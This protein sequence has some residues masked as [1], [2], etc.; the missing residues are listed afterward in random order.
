MGSSKKEETC[1]FAFI[2]AKEREW[3]SNMEHGHE[4][5]FAN[6]ATKTSLVNS[7][8][9]LW[10]RWILQVHL[11][12]TKYI[13]STISMKVW[14]AFFSSNYCCTF[15][16]YCTYI[17][18]PFDFDDFF[19]SGHGQWCGCRCCCQYVEKKTRWRCV[20]PGW[21]FFCI[22]HSSIRT[23]LCSRM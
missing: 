7:L 12:W 10:I 23:M 6:V 18:H 15:C 9:I 3:W 20:Q 16:T 1:T 14:A 4:N 8:E 21:I 5:T 2:Y 22:D 17:V 13:R 19:M 11:F